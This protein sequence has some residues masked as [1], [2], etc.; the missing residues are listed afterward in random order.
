MVAADKG[1]AEKVMALLDA[2]ANVKIADRA[3]RTAADWATA[4]ADD[5]GAKV[6]KALTEA[7]AR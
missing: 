5:E 6:L 7:Q 1:D 4:R 2:G 3:G